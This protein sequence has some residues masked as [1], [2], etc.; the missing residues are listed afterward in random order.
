ME[1]SVIIESDGLHLEGLLSEGTKPFGIVV[2][3]PHPLY[4]GDMHN[5]VVTVVTDFFQQKDFYTLRFDFRGV[6][7]S[8]GTYDEGEGEQKDVAAAIGFLE[9]QGV[10]KVVLA[11][12]SF[13]AWV[14]AKLCQNQSFEGDMIMVSPP[15]GFIDFSDIEKLEALKLVISGQ[16]DDIAPPDQIK[17]LLPVWNPEANFKVLAG[18]DHFYGGDKTALTQALAHY[19]ED[20]D[21]T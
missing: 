2:T 12:Y 16:N 1:K 15:V 18:G 17:E 3:H 10:K 13:G 7:G 6:G 4:G 11:G 14:N 20:K 19:F 5:H 8:Q 21:L 9:S